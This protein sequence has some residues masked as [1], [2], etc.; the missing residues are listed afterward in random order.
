MAATLDLTFGGH[1]T[2]GI[3][4]E[5]QDAFAVWQPTSSIAAYKGVGCCLADGVSCSENAQQASVTAVTHFLNDYYSTPDSWDVK[6]AAGKVLSSLNSWL[7]HQ[8]QQATA[9]HN[10]LV[11]TF[12]G[13]IFKSNTMH[14]FHAGDSRIYRL[15]QGNFECLTRDHT[16]RVGKGREY[17]SRAL[18]MDSRVEIDY[19]SDDIEA[20][21]VL[22]LTSDGVHGF[23]GDKELKTVLTNVE[24]QPH[25]QHELEKLASGLTSRSLENGADDNLTALVI[26]VNAVP[27]PDLEEAHRALTARAIPPVLKV[28]DK[29][30]HYEVE[31]VMFSGTRSH[32]Y[33]VLNHRNQKY[34]ALKVPSLNF[35]D[36]MVYLEGFVRE[37][38]IGN[39]IDHPNVMK[40]EPPL[41]GGRFMYHVCELIEGISLRQWIDDHP[42]ADLADVRALTEQIIH[43]LRALQRMGMVHRDVK[44]EN[45]M[46]T[47]KGQVKVIDFGTVS[48]RGLAE[49]KSAVEEDVP[50]GSVNYIAPEYVIDGVADNRSDLFGLAV[51]VYEMLTGE[52]PYRMSKVHRS[53]A[54][55][56]S[57]WQYMPLTERRKDIPK[58][59]DLAIEKGCHPDIHKRH[60]AY[61]EFWADFTSPNS[62]L[63]N[64]YDSKPLIAR[65]GLDFWKGTALALLAIAVLEALYIAY[66]GVI[67]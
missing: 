1:S 27:K 16:H 24:K 42:K 25:S 63:I 15:R 59:I 47:R 51:M 26:R 49:V 29:I 34:Y 4:P 37:Q 9:R 5:N 65:A 2:A 6:T 36:D 14:L 44:P 21:D 55:S 11:T 38:W 20:G 10:S 33:K 54:K 48:V 57:E 56:T 46:I 50:V 62:E 64:K 35:E 7:F 18:G 43:G 45:I 52:Q 61:S 40:I 41:A 28:G 66:S 32:L 53:G 12:S 30:D 8:G 19:L 3:K 13:L 31:S 23:V 17:L 39:R 60:Q 22:L 67:H 58:W